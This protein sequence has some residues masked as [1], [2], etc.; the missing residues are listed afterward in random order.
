MNIITQTWNDLGLNLW[1]M[2]AWSVVVLTALCLVAIVGIAGGRWQSERK[3]RKT[4]TTSE[5]FTQTIWSVV[6]G[7]TS[8]QKATEVL[9]QNEEL[10]MVALIEA[11]RVSSKDPGVRRVVDD[12]I[13]AMHLPEHQRSFFTHHKGSAKAKAAA[14]LGA[15]HDPEAVQEL[16]T[17]VDDKDPDVQ[18][19]AARSLAQVGSLEVLMQALERLQRYEYISSNRLTELLETWGKGRS[20]ELVD[21]FSQHPQLSAKLKASVLQALSRLNT[22]LEG[23]FLSGAAQHEDHEVKISAVKGMGRW[24][25][26]HGDDVEDYLQHLPLAE[27]EQNQARQDNIR[28]HFQAVMGTIF[29]HLQDEDWRV[30]AMS[31]QALCRPTTHMSLNALSKAMSDKSWMVRHHAA[32][33]LSQTPQGIHTLEHVLEFSKDPFAKDMA[34]SQLDEIHLA[35]LDVEKEVA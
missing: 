31:A 34:Q 7:K 32:K 18:L 35:T 14:Y 3:Q 27:P 15:L 17:S 5:T 2:A 6:Q 13:Q 29:L 26:V 11:R 8:I 21:Y 12:L 23:D 25:M 1:S 24:V 16:L 22:A 4:Y 28:K 33:S 30:R 19:A 9:G 10:A 20:Q